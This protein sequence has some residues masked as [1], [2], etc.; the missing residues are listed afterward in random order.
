[1]GMDSLMRV[2]LKRRFE[3]G[4]GLRP[5]TLDDSPISTDFGA[6]PDLDEEKLFPTKSPI[7]RPVADGQ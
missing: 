4:T 7:E 6:W 1:M 3:A 2:R 5:G